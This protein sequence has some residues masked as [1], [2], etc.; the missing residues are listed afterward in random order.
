MGTPKDFTSIG[1]WLSV[2]WIY[3]YSFFN[4]CEHNKALKFTKDAQVIDAVLDPTSI[5]FGKDDLVLKA[6]CYYCTGVYADDKRTP[7]T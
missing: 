5:G 3:A 4:D 7:N 6:T 2:P 1:S